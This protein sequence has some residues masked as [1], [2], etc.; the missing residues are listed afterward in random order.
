M[1]KSVAVMPATTSRASIPD[2]S[3]VLAERLVRVDAPGPR[4]VVGVDDERVDLHA[5][6]RLPTP[7]AARSPCRRKAGPRWLAS[8][9]VQPLPRGDRQWCDPVRPALSRN[10]P[11]RAQHRTVKPTSWSSARLPPSPAPAPPTPRA[12]VIGML[13]TGRRIE[14]GHVEREQGALARRLAPHRT[15]RRTRRPARRR[16]TGYGVHDDLTRAPTRRRR[17]CAARPA[18]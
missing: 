17:R 6:S 18:R 13:E 12:A 1:V 3:P 10:R 7:S 15:R 4:L 16:S 14:P 2:E 8:D 5:C 11:E 9:I